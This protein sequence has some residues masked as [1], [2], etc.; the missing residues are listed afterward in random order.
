MKRKGLDS[1]SVDRAGLLSVLG[2]TRGVYSGRAGRVVQVE[3]SEQGDLSVI[4]DGGV[5]AAT[6]T[7]KAV[8]E[9]AGFSMRL[10]HDRLTSAVKAVVGETVR[11]TDTDRGAAVMGSTSGIASVDRE[12]AE[13]VSASLAEPQAPE[14]VLPAGLFRAAM[15]VMWAADESD[16]RP[17]FGGVAL[18]SAAVMATNGT[19]LAHATTSGPESLDLVLAKTSVRLISELWDGASDVTCR[20]M[21]DRLWARGHGW[22][23]RAV[24]LFDKL[25]DMDAIVRERP[26]LSVALSKEGILDAL[27]RAAFARDKQ[28]RVT[29]NSGRL[30]LDTTS[31]SD[32]IDVETS[33][34]FDGSLVALFD[35]EYLTRVMEECPGDAIS[36][37]WTGPLSPFYIRSVEH[38]EYT[39]VLMPQRE[40]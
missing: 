17:V 16:P 40:V 6:M 37:Q 9:G 3:V 11:M 33:P 35:R 26:A 7:L 29:I 2:K 23:L 21:H 18:T 31:F 38:T 13:L 5:L 1:V 4:A 22:A 32:G 30:L 19:Y 24:A 20:V 28:V 36:F 25:P 15:D 8:V 39:S 34:D 12:P 14:V 10:D 27:K